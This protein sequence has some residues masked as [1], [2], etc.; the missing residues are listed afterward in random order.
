MGD[1]PSAD[2]GGGTA[3]DVSPA[4]CMDDRW[5]LGD[6]GAFLAETLESENSD[7]I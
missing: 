5:T 6:G 1:I 2:G 4:A 7:Y 3:S